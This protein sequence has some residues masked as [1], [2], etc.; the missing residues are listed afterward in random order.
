VIKSGSASAK[1]LR[2]GDCIS[3][4]DIDE[5]VYRVDL[6]PCG[7]SHNAEVIGQ[8]TL[9]DGPYPGEPER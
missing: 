3:G 6:A 2:T 8:F 5:T 7:E 9:P 4:L 1:L